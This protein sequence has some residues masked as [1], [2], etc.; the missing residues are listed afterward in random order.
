[1]KYADPYKHFSLTAEVPALTNALTC[2]LKS[3]MLLVTTETY[4]HLSRNDAPR[5]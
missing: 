1:M 3:E 4:T 5:C 2:I